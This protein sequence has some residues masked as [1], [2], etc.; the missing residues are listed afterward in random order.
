MGP[1]ILT[2]MIGVS[3]RIPGRAARP[4][5]TLWLIQAC[6][7]FWKLSR[8]AATSGITYGVTRDTG[9]GETFFAERGARYVHAN[10]LTSTA[11]PRRKQVPV[12][13]GHGTGTAR[14]WGLRRLGTGMGPLD[15]TSMGVGD[16]ST[17]SEIPWM[18][19]FARNRAR[20]WRLRAT[21]RRAV[22]EAHHGAIA[23][24]GAKPGIH[25]SR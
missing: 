6:A 15:L 24:H 2:S 9:S 16:P 14:V 10:S 20:P 17:I 3:R 8:W 11:L 7:L 1:I 18:P 5:M 21:P 23:T 22:A 25:G 4:G 19:G 13:L 12:A